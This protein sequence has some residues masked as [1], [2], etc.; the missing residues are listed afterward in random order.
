MTMWKERYQF[1]EEVRDNAHEM[2]KKI[3]ER[4]GISCKNLKHFS[5]S[6]TQKKKEK[7]ESIEWWKIPLELKCEN[8][9]RGK[10][11]VSCQVALYVSHEPQISIYLFRT[12][13]EKKNT[14]KIP[15]FI[16]KNT[17]RQRSAYRKCWNEIPSFIL[18]CKLSLD[19]LV[20]QNKRSFNA[21]R[22][23]M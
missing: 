22:S 17:T 14:P 4:N 7:P 23:K 11:T 12:I 3:P 15:F 20:L 13:V 18:F 21:T 10:G 16:E 8:N 9:V 1:V 6:H 19:F 5:Y 2:D